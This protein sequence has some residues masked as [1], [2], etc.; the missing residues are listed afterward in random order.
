M[1]HRQSYGQMAEIIGNK[2]VV[3]LAIGRDLK[4]F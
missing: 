4:T 1:Q 3:Q 2:D